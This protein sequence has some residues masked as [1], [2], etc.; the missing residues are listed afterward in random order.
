[1]V[2]AGLGGRKEPALKDQLLS[3]KTLE[4]TQPPTPQS[5]ADLE[6]TVVDLEELEALLLPSELVG[7][8]YIG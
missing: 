5:L 3:N 7:S 1:L 8:Y 2:W 4:E 6:D